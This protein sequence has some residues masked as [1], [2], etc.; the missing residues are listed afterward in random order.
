MAPASEI[1][2]SWSSHKQGMN[3]VQL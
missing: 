3:L 2:H 1:F